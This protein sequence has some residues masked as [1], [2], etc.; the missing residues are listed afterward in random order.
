MDDIFRRRIQLTL[1]SP[2]TGD[3]PGAVARLTGRGNAVRTVR[4]DQMVIWSGDGM[5]FGIRG[6]FRGPSTLQM[7]YSVR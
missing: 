1:Y 7:A 5:V 3:R 4:V 2:H 6:N